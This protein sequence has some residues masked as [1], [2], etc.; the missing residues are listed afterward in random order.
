MKHHI[1]FVC[2]Y[3]LLFWL[4]GLLRVTLYG[5]R[6][7]DNIM[8]IVYAAVAIIWGTSISQRIMDS[9]CKG[10]ILAIMGL[11]EFFF[12][13]QV[14]NYRLFG[15]SDTIRR[16]CWY[17]YYIP[18]VIIPLLLLYLGVSI[19]NM[20]CGCLKTKR[21]LGP[22]AVVAVACIGAVFTNDV[23]FK[24]FRFCGPDMLPGSDK[25]YGPLYYLILA[26]CVS[27][28]VTSFIIILREGT[29]SNVKRMV[30]IPVVPM[31]LGTGYFALYLAGKSLKI[32]NI[33][34]WTI[35]E[36]VSFVTVFFIESCIHIGLIPANTEYASIF[37]M[38]K[39]NVRIFNKSGEEYYST[40]DALFAADNENVIIKRADIKGG[41]VEWAVD[42]SEIREL[43]QMIM[44][45][46]EQIKT[47]NEYLRSENDL[48]AEYTALETRNHLYDTIAS[49]LKPQLDRIQ[50]LL[51]E[52]EEGDFKEYLKKICV[53]NAYIK[54]RSNME[55]M[56]SDSEVLPLMELYL[57]MSESLRYV[58]LFGTQ[59]MLVTSKDR[60]LVA[61][62]VI[63]LYEFFETV[64]ELTLGEVR[65]MSVTVACSDSDINMRIMLSG[66]FND[67]SKVST[68]YV[69]HKHL[70][71]EINVENDAT[72]TYI[73]YKL[74]GGE[75]I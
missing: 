43:D 65:F 59:T 10:I 42:V 38:L 52:A 60:E 11:L 69:S 37:R 44:D 73:S 56:M 16:Y 5:V 72:D 48:K 20:R 30:W 13:C 31:M 40:K 41:S 26:V 15:E 9:T 21:W 66:T 4:S 62:L 28:I 23:H 22:V 3:L 47:R 35:G 36:T 64:L 58:E 74:K 51:K 32:C 1:R 70:Q 71:V 17:A 19:R 49:L 12:F 18:I 68:D 6:F 2:G 33:S 14:C 53:L 27:I 54:R 34:L 55:L 46:T 67:L 7:A 8:L 45:A 39:M 29:R 24:V 63:D 61:D 57:A 25:S 75:A 50:T